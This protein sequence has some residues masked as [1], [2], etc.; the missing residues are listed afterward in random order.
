MGWVCLA[1]SPAPSG[2]GDEAWLELSPR[3]ARPIV[4]R[5]GPRADALLALGIR[6]ISDRAVTV[7]GV[8]VAV[9]AGERVLEI[10]P[11]ERPFFRDEV[12]R[13]ATRIDGGR[14]VEWQAICFDALQPDA[15][16]LRF[17]FDLS[18]PGGRRLKQSFGV[19]L[20]PSPP[21][22][23]LELPF[24]GLWR[25]TQGHSCSSNHRSGGFGGDF[26]WDFAALGPSGRS[27]N[28]QYE[29]SGRNVD[30][31]TFGRPVLAPIAGRVVRAVDGVPDNE[32][33][34]TFP[35][36]SLL[37]S[38]ERPAWIF[39]NFVVLDLGEGHHVLLG[40]LQEGS[41]AVR[42]GEAVRPG[43]LLGRGGNSGNT[44]DP[45]LH[46]QVMDRP[47]PADRVV[48]GLPAVLEDYVEY[49]VVGGEDR[50][51]LLASRVVRGDPLE[52][53]IIGPAGSGP[54]R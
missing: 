45:H 27:V 32:G 8:G 12:F 42:A 16:R 40:H 26:S 35:R 50:K 37:E 14:R 47:D 19:P 5:G 15:D 4:H 3:P 2:G 54:G 11:L 24:E 28:D 53:A 38:A 41:V 20:D 13:R 17:D 1:G 23:S 52:G 21:A 44:I 30:S 10:R 34:K 29:R 31:Y 7:R 25:V 43:D 48:R 18:A 22:V 9:L 33:L 36:R 49:T 6:N 46:L 39:G 51:D